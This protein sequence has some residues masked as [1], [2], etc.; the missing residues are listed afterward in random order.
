MGS[1]NPANTRENEM[2]RLFFS[3]YLMMFCCTLAYIGMGFAIENVIVRD[4]LLYDKGNDYIGGFHLLDQLHQRLD[5]EAFQKVVADYPSY[6][7]V[8]LT[9]FD[10]DDLNLAEEQLAQLKR[11]EVY[12]A[13]PEDQ[14]LYYQL[15]QSNIVARFGPMHTYEPLEKVRVSHRSA[16]FIVM[17]LAVFLWML[18]LQYK[19]KRL[20]QAATQLGTGD[21]GVRVSER[22]KHRIGHLNRTFNLMAERIERLI[23][24]HKNLTNAVAHELRTPVARIQFQLDMMHE[25]KDDEKRKNFT[26]GISDDITELS[27]LVDELLTYARFDREGP[28]IEL[29]LYSLHDSLLNIIAARHFHSN[30]AVFYDDSWFLADSELQSMPFEPKHLERAI[31][32]LVTNA[33]KYG[34]S[35]IQIQV[36][37]DQQN[38]TIYVDD[39]GPG[40][41]EEDRAQIFDP[42]KRLDDSRTRSTGGYGLGLAIVKQVAQW[43]GGNVSIEQAPIGGARFVFTWPILNKGFT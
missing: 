17:A 22:G 14:L 2:V 10:L 15:T 39:D 31:G 29:Q 16:L 23:K 4:W 43:H 8:P 6:A 21:F 5:N 38:C 36:R 35:K 40:I 18:N 20:E 27:D 42:F 19:F 12:V 33:Q 11:G 37:R 24:G 30:S 41:P 26:Y 9:L 25:E 32:N 13:N 7:N 1:F 3:L 28:A 34:Q